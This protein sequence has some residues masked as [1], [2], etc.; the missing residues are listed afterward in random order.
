MIMRTGTERV[1]MRN[2]R[3]NSRRR[4]AVSAIRRRASSIEPEDIGVRI[5]PTSVKIGDDLRR[6][7][8]KRDAIAA[9]AERKISTGK[10]WSLTDVG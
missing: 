10:F 1:T 2:S 6:N 5:R 7:D 8:A 3:R 4:A 9:V